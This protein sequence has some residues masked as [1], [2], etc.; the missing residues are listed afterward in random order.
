M[1]RKY[2]LAGPATVLSTEWQSTVEVPAGQFAIITDYEGGPR[3]SPLSV[4]QSHEEAESALRGRVTRRELISMARRHG[5]D[6]AFD[7]L[8][9]Q[10]IRDQCVAVR[11]D[12][13]WPDWR[14][15]DW[16]DRVNEG[17]NAHELRYM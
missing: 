13:D 2:I 7:E 3:T 1:T 12:M 6:G 17:G 10:E 8:T 4:F 16:T 11:P 5:V 14:P 9:T 15:T